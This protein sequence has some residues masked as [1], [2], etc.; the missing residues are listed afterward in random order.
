M[1]TQ[2][3]P[4]PASLAALVA[5]T[6]LAAALRRDAAAPPTLAEALR[7]VGPRRVTAAEHE[8]PGEYDAHLV[9]QRADCEGNVYALRFLQRP[10]I[11][12]RVRLAGLLLVGSAT[13]YAAVRRRLGD[14]PQGAPLR[15]A[16]D[17]TVRALRTIGYR[18]TPFLVIAERG[19][20]VKMTLQLPSSPEEL[21]AFA[22]LLP[23][24]ASVTPAPRWSR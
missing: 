9:M 10:G 14:A 8:G 4:S 5:A 6:I 17:A 13:D 7:G 19:G 12:Q 16:D 2:Q 23:H 3:S 22:R 15:R 18:S 11:R 20:G 21:A 24:L 1:T